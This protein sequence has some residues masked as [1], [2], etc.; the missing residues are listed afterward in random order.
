M[1][2]GGLGCRSLVDFL[3]GLKVWGL[4]VQGFCVRLLLNTTHC[5]LSM[6]CGRTRMQETATLA[7]L[8]ALFPT[9]YCI[10]HARPP[11]TCK[12]ASYRGA[13]LNVRGVGSSILM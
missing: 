10:E 9:L 8:R 2:L 5:C 7:K 1:D 4:E 11:P 13:S 3:G 12:T 6:A